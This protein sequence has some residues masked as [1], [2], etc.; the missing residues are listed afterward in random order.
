M[1]V[2]IFERGILVGSAT[3]KNLDPP[4]GVAFGPFLPTPDYARDA[5][6]NVVEGQYVGDRGLVLVAIA[7]Q[8]GALDASIAIED[9]ADVE[10]G[11]QLTLFFRDGENFAA[12]FAQHPDYMA[13]FT[14]CAN[15][16]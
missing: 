2:K 12:L 7:D 5:H 3:L 15:G 11:A 16:S 13:Y 1:H 10:F 9:W 6:A 8:R 14:S 4:M